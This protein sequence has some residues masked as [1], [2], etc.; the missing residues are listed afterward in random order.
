LEVD[1]FLDDREVVVQSLDPRLGKIRD[2]SAAAILEDGSPVLIFD[3]QD[4]V[5]S[6]ERAVASLPAPGTSGDTAHFSRRA[7]KRI[8]VVD[9]SITVRELLR[10]IL[11][12]NGY[13]V[14][15]A[16]D[17]M[18]GWTL[19]RTGE[20]DLCITDRDMPRL[21]GLEMVRMFKRDARLCRL[22]ILM[23]SHKDRE[24]DRLSGLEAGVDE[25]ITKSG[26][27][28]KSLLE[29]VRRTLDEAKP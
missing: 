7:A 23:V 25:Y 16:V 18:D 12:E 2:V 9:D 8:L 5:R 26:F 20:F 4:L 29:V 15:M 13:V 19:A 24:Q 14:E 3:V 22:P 1:A 28:D 11:T 27:Q 21:D 17:G 10:K 6:A